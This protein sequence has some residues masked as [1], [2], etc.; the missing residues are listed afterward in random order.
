MNLK[1]LSDPSYI[2]NRDIPDR[3]MNDVMGMESRMNW[4]EILAIVG[5]TVGAI[6]IFAVYWFVNYIIIGW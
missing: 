1:E 6:I 5:W 2:M 4:K 3:L